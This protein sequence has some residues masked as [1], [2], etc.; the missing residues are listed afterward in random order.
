LNGHKKFGFFDHETDTQKVASGE[1]IFEAGDAGD[2]MFYVR[3]G[4]VDIMV[5]DSVINSHG[6]GE[7]FGEMS[8]IDTKLRSA[9]AVATSDCELL[10]VDERRFL[11]LVQQHPYFALDMMRVLSERLRRRTES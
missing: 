2:A 3:A 6:P 10:P 1:T 11:Y 5:G 8:I 4:T 9:T 7:V